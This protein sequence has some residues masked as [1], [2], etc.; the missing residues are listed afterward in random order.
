MTNSLLPAAIVEAWD[1]A[2]VRVRKLEGGFSGAA[3]YHC[4]HRDGS[5]TALR[6][7]PS[8]TA[9]ERV[10]EVQ[11]VV[12]EAR[13]R[14]CGLVP[15]IIETRTHTTLVTLADRHWEHSQW[16]PG[17]PCSPSDDPQHLESAV[18]LAAAAVG[19]FHAAVRQLGTR[20]DLSA[21]VVQRCERLAAAEQWLQQPPLATDGARWPAWLI[22]VDGVLRAAWPRHQ[23]RLQAGLAAARSQRT[24][25][26]YVLRDCHHA[27]I[28]FDAPGTTVSG[29]IDFD[30]L[31]VDTPAT[32]LARLVHSF[33]ALSR[34]QPGI[35]GGP[36]EDPP[37]QSGRTLSSWRRWVEDDLWGA[38]VAGIREHCSFTDQQCELAR[39]IA[40][41][42][43]LLSLVNW[44]T[45]ASS[46]PPHRANTLPGAEAVRNRVEQ[47]SRFAINYLT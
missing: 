26:Q 17:E 47:L 43:T 10:A 38:A 8:G 11:R 5:E 33:A 42:T 6:C 30:A 22:R 23:H 39:L 20:S 28:L 16:M 37:I 34:P 18:R 44:A 12:G 21:A 14:G 2:D 41:S 15:Q 7:W 31:R 1:L 29:L 40:D 13:R 19:Q 32:D 24:N 3:I 35:I 4:R 36:S 46:N 27:H 25:V 45:W 9:A